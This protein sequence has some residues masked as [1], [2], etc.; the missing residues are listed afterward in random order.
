M[1]A[2][3]EKFV[4]PKVKNGVV[5]IWLDEAGIIN[6]SRKTRE[7]GF[8]KFDAITPFPVHGI[9]D[10]LGYDFSFIPW[11]TFAAGLTGACLGLLLTWWTGSVDYPVTI[12]GKPHWAIASFIPIIFELTILFASLTSVG[13]LL[14]LCGLPK[15]DPPIIDPDLTSHKFALFVPQDDVGYDEAKILDMFKKLGASEARKAQF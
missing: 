13:A 4:K 9:D 2:L 7:A 11:I 15:V 3:I 6:A 5:G 1:K 8:K 10:A 14:Y 12:G